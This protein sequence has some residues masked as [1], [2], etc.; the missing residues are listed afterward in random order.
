[1]SA[2]HAAPSRAS[3]PPGRFPVAMALTVAGDLRFLAHHDELRAVTRAV[4]RARWP[5]AYSHGYNPQP[6]VRIPLPRNLGVAAV[7]HWVL[8][9]LDVPRAPD[10]LFV[11]LVAALPPGLVLERVVA[12]AP[13]GTPHPQIATYELTLDPAT[14]APLAPRVAALLAAP[15]I[16]IE[17][18]G[19]PGARP[20]PFDLRPYLDSLDLVGSTLTM[21]LRFVAQRTARPAEVLQALGLPVQDCGHRLRRTAVRWDMELAGPECGPHTVT[22]GTEFV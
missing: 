11:G 4:I 5:L 1:M 21:R 19:A 8:V 13:R 14:A 17:R 9:D 22:K 16:P 3:P 20:R 10:D 15:Q 12:P 18:T 2:A 7:A 6:R